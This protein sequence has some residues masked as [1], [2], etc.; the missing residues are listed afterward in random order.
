M[1]YRKGGFRMSRSGKISMV[2]PTLVRS[3]RILTG[4]V[5]MPR[6]VR[7]FR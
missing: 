1:S 7:W 6:S 3:P 5:K 2:R 4:T